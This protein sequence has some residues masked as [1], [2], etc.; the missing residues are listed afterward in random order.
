VW[1]EMVFF[2]VLVIAIVILERNSIE[3]SRRAGIVILNDHAK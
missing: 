3:R 1:E 2:G